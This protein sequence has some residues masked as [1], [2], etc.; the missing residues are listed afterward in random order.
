MYNFLSQCQTVLTEANSKE[1]WEYK[2]I[3]LKEQQ[4]VN[5]YRQQAYHQQS[6]QM[7][8]NLINELTRHF[9]DQKIYRFLIELIQKLIKKIEI[10]QQTNGMVYTLK[11]HL[12]NQLASLEYAA[13]NIDNFPSLISLKDII[14]TYFNTTLLTPPFEVNPFLLNLFDINYVRNIYLT[15]FNQTNQIPLQNYGHVYTPNYEPFTFFLLDDN[16]ET[17]I[18]S[19][20]SSTTA[21]S[22]YSYQQYV[23]Q[24]HYQPCQ[25]QQ[26]ITDSQFQQ[27][28][29]QQNVYQQ[30]PQSQIPYNNQ[31]LNVY[32]E[33][34]Y[35]NIPQPQI[36]GYS[37]SQYPTFTYVS[38][39]QP[40]IL[41]FHYNQ[42]QNYNNQSTTYGQNF[43]VQLQY[44][45]NQGQVDYTPQSYPHYM[46]QPQ[47]YPQAPG[48]QNSIQSPNVNQIAS[49]PPTQWP[50][51][52]LSNNNQNQVEQQYQQPQAYQNQMQ[53]PYHPQNL[54]M[55]PQYQQVEQI[56]NYNINP[57]KECNYPQNQQQVPSSQN[58]QYESYE[59]KMVQSQI[60]QSVSQVPDQ[61]ESN[62]QINV[63]SNNQN[64]QQYLNQEN[65]N[66]K[67]QM[68]DIRQAKSIY[69]PQIPDNNTQQKYQNPSN[70]AQETLQQQALP[71]PPPPPPPPPHQVQTPEDFIN[72]NK[73]NQQNSILDQRSLNDQEIQQY[74][75]QQQND[76]SLFEA[77][78]LNKSLLKYELIDSKGCPQL[79]QKVQ[80]KQDRDMKGFKNHDE[81]ALFILKCYLDGKFAQNKIDR[82]EEMKT[83]VNF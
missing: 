83:L 17:Q 11:P 59:Q 61:Y 50:Q 4:L 49:F 58:V 1:I 14:F 29:S 13:N 81:H 73:I 80:Y 48:N 78:F 68:Q 41:G 18:T 71:P 26:Y 64:T 25:N 22:Q 28:Q 47:T 77:L 30:Q 45:A 35:S 60:P 65:P 6:Y 75:L 32:S 16:I 7:A 43:N 33:K 53:P 76:N 74:S 37:N 46:S 42:T 12:G 27:Q 10:I 54:S 3:E 63:N 39:P 2:Q 67:D 20:P 8:Q 55:E 9:R 57:N 66:Q 70:Q 44:F 62:N 19:Q 36:Q 15:L 40:Q 79:N 5:L 38:T 34:P 82:T 24:N 31:N 21:Y 51:S 52:N 23:P 56:N 72:L 69:T